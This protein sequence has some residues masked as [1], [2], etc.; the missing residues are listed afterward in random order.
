MRFESIRPEDVFRH[1]GNG[2]G[3]LVD[4]REKEDYVKGHIP[5]AVNIPYDELQNRIPELTELTRPRMCG[6]SVFVILY[7]ERGNTSLL[8]ARDLYQA[9]FWV[10]NVYGG[11][12]DYHGPL[13]SSPLT[14]EEKAVTIKQ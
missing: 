14:E 4:V 2:K 1:R 13:V 12:S 3:V 5:G 11:I 8:A 6:G 10:K 9:G 7:C